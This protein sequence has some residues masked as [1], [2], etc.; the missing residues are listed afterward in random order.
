VSIVT[1]ASFAIPDERES[2]LDPS[3]VGMVIFLMTELMFFAGMIVA[4]SVLWAQEP[5][6]PP[7]G[8]PRLPMGLSVVNTIVLLTSG[9]CLA[10]ALRRPDWSR[11]LFRSSL[12]LGTLFLVVQGYE[13][14]RMLEHGLTAYSG[15]VYG[16][17]FYAIIGSHAAHA[18]AGLGVLL[19]MNNR[20]T[21]EGFGGKI[22][23]YLVPSLFW[24]FVVGVWPIL[25]VTLYGLG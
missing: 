21:E 24:F 20:L 8:Q 25:F 10:E 14:V 18:L 5:S 11:L 2:S 9:L 13:W 22:S 17:F 19:W 3:L 23:E 12:V 16:G 15:G 4:H 6:W 1:T 7:P